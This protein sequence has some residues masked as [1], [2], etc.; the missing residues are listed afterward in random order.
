MKKG[1]RKART[2]TQSGSRSW[3]DGDNA[4]ADNADYIYGV[5]RQ[6]CRRWQLLYAWF[7]YA[8]LEELRAREL[9]SL[10]HRHRSPVAVRS[11]ARDVVDLRLME[12]G[13]PQGFPVAFAPSEPA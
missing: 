1:T 11:R 13:W 3:G 8:P 9:E 4:D 5:V 7:P 12:M 10:H 6:R 2:R